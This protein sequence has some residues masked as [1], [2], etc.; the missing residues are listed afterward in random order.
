MCTSKLRNL[1]FWKG[2]TAHTVVDRLSKYVILI[3]RM[4]H[5]HSHS[6]DLCGFV[7]LVATGSS[8]SLFPLNISCQS[9]V[10]CLLCKWEYVCVW[11]IIDLFCKFLAC[12]SLADCFGN[13]YLKWRGVVRM[14]SWQEQPIYGCVS[15]S[16]TSFMHSWCLE[17]SS[18]VSWILMCLGM[19]FF[20][21][22]SPTLALFIFC[23]INKDSGDCCVQ[24]SKFRSV[25]QSKFALEKVS[26]FQVLQC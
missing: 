5:G 26:Q 2:R 11:I 20:Y 4:K 17:Y 14:P 10:L 3:V 12:E 23:I 13:W 24:V 6:R 21:V 25:F 16:N 19:L 22:Y 9:L 8:V 15:I 18:S 1:T 7:A